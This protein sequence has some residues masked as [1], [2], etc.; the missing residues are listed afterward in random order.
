[1]KNV[2]PVYRAGVA[3]V[4]FTSFHAA[5]KKVLIHS[6]AH[7]RGIAGYFTSGSVLETA[8]SPVGSGILDVG[9][10]FEDAKTGYKV[11]VRSIADSTAA[12]DVSFCLENNATQ[13]QCNFLADASPC[14]GITR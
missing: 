14:D 9:E 8:N 10:T 2:A 7:T 5:T 11:T 12:V 6:A 4:Y 13:D 3:S 1:M